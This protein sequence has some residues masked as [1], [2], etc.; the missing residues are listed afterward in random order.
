MSFIWPKIASRNLK[1][2]RQPGN[3]EPVRRKATPARI[4]LALSCTI[5]SVFWMACGGGGSGGGGTN[6]VSKA[7]SATNTS[8]VAVD[9]KRQRAYVPLQ[10]LSDAG[11]GQ[12]AV[13]DLS[14]DPDQGNPVI[15]IIDLGFFALPPAAAADIKPARWWCWPIRLPIRNLARHQ[16]GRHP[17]TTVPFLPAAALPIPRSCHRRHQRH[18]AGIIE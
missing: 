18:G 7:T 10:F 9:C 16:R 5:G 17:F 11:N 15:A 13:L 1:H 12:L 2:N 4:A 3:H 8:I 6:T 14:I